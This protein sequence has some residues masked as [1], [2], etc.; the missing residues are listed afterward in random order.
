[1]KLK[2]MM[3]A[4]IVL[5]T[6]ST[7][8]FADPKYKEL[9]GLSNRVFL[10]S[11]ALSISDFEVRT[12]GDY[13]NISVYEKMY[14]DSSGML[15]YH[16]GVGELGTVKGL[17]LTYEFQGRAYVYYNGKFAYSAEITESLK[18]EIKQKNLGTQLYAIS[19][20]QGV[21]IE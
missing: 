18:K 6:A 12:N 1:M 7:S 16:D 10:S 13:E 19:N 9:T 20:Y 5:M 17:I 2:H 8:S 11:A 4:G 3:V 14:S 21:V 15:N